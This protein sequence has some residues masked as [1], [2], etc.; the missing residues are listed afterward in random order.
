M[1]YIRSATVPNLQK[2]EGR[3]ADVRYPHPAETRRGGMPMAFQVTSP[4]DNRMALLPHAL[5]LHVNPA[6]FSESHTKKIER[7]QTRGGWVEQ[8]WGDEL[9]DIS[10]DGS[11]GA[12]VNLYTGLSSVVRQRTIAWDRYRDLYDLYRNNGSIY[13]PFGNIV[14]QGQIQ[15]LYDRGSYIG[16]FRNFN[17]EETAD[18]P[19]A[20]K[21]SWSFKVEV[22]LVQIPNGQALAPS[23]QPPLQGPAPPQSNSP[24]PVAAPQPEATTTPVP[25]PPNTVITD[26]NRSMDIDAYDA[27]VAAGTTNEPPVFN[28]GDVEVKNEPPVFNLGEVEVKT[29]KSPSGGTAVPKPKK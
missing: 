8:H 18:S 19:F 5:V 6:S 16:T 29:T 24:S 2:L 21:I 7:L 3:S 13:D 15:L 12:F 4:F 11:T 27:E 1:A 10:C 17:V 23:N 14:L 28:L 20:F 25:V 22:C 26:T 9:T